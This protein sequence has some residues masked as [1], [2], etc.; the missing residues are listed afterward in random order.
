MIK[1]LSRIE[2]KVSGIKEAQ[3]D[4]AKQLAI[5][6]QSLVDHM[7]RTQLLEQQVEKQR[8]RLESIW[9]RSL[10]PL[11]IISTLVML[12]EKLLR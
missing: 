11:A 5:Y 4:V 1:R 6:N 3:I 12:A 9:Q 2:K 7:R 10:A 8:E